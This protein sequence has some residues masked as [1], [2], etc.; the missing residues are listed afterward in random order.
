MTLGTFRDQLIYPDSV[1]DM[2]KKHITD[3]DLENIVEQVGIFS[4]HS[5]VFEKFAP[6]LSFF[7]I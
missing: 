2:K 3:M 7:L 6:C 1:E 5:H 4:I